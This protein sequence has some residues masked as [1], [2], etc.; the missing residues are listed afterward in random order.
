M[1]ANQRTFFE[2]IN[3]TWVTPIL[4]IITAIYGFIFKMNNDKLTEASLKLNNLKTQVDTEL[5]QKEFNKNLKMTIYKEV[6]E[7]ISKKDTGLQNATLIV[8]NEMLKDDSA[9]REKLKTV[10]F[11]SSNAK[12]LIKVQKNIDQF[13]ETDIQTKFQIQTGTF[14]IGVFYLEDI[15]GES[16]PCADKVFALLKSKYPGYNIRKR[17]L[18]K[19]VNARSGYRID[20]NQIRYEPKESSTASEIKS[21]IAAGNIFKNEEPIL[22]TTTN[23]TPNYISIFVRNI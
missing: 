17:L 21:I 2:R 22:R 8:V 11:A 19:E 13:A 18:P 3:T 14:T 15:P 9:L 1:E 10:L 7:A 12:D 20:S 4:A 5:K 23:V 6:K 16:I